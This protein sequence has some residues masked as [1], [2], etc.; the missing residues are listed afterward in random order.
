MKKCGLKIS[1]NH[2]I[3]MENVCS[4]F[5]EKDIIHLTLSN[6]GI[7][8]LVIDEV[9]DK[10]SIEYTAISINEFKRIEREVLEYLGVK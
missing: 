6:E 8:Q 7:K 10:Y 9:K 2:Y 1:D 3:N 5:I 4:F